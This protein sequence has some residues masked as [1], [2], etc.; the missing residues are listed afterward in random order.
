[1]AL[2]LFAVFLAAALQGE[3]DR[4]LYGHCVSRL[5]RRELNLIST[6]SLSKPY[7]VTVTEGSANSAVLQWKMTQ[8]PF[9][10]DL[11]KVANLLVSIMKYF[12]IFDTF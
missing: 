5:T 1:M 7:D 10:T 11:L 4:Y 12:L 3:L 8:N 9:T 6:V 2:T